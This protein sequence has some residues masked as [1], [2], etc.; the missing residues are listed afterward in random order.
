[1]DKRYRRRSGRQGVR[2]NQFKLDR[3]AIFFFFFRNARSDGDNATTVISFGPLSR[4]FTLTTIVRPLLYFKK[5][6]RFRGD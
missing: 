1:M 2:F 4:P 6:T 5:K 3:L